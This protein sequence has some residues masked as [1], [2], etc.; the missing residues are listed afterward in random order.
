[1]RSLRSFRGVPAASSS[2]AR[3]RCGLG[4]GNAMASTLGDRSEGMAN[5]EPGLVAFTMPD[6][7]VDRNGAILLR[8]KIV[9]CYRA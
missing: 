4:A 8:D 1:M 7:V 5:A 6:L 2:G 9:A 3:S